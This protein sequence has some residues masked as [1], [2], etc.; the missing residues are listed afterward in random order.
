MKKNQPDLQLNAHQRHASSF[1]LTALQHAYW[2][3]EQNAYRLHTPAYLHGC[4]FS[5][6]IDIP[7]LEAAILAVVQSQPSLT[8][9]ILDDGTQRPLPPPNRIAVSVNDYSRVTQETAKQYLAERKAT[10]ESELPP[11]DRGLRFA[12]FIDRVANGYYV[13]F[14]FRLIA[15][16]AMSIWLFLNDMCAA[17]MG[18]GMPKQQEARFA[19]FVRQRLDLMKSADYERSLKYWQE[20]A[21]ELPNAPELP[22]VDHD[23]I[24]EKSEFRRIQLNLNAQQVEALH[25]QARKHGVGV[26]NLLCTMYADVLRLWSKNSSFIINMLVTH[27]PDDGRFS[28]V[29]GNFGSTVPVEAEDVPGGLRERARALQR[30][31]LPNLKHMRVPGVEVIRAMGRSGSILPAMPVVFASSLGLPMRDLLSP[32]DIGWEVCAGGLQTPQVLLD[33]QVYMD[34]DLLRLNWDYVV[35][36]FLPGV[37]EDMFRAFSEQ[38]LDVIGEA[39]A[40]GL[41]LPQV[42]ESGL[43]ARKAANASGKRLQTGLLHDFFAQACR[44]YPDRPA[45][46]SD[47]RTLA[48]GELWRMTTRLAAE[49]RERQVGRN[50]LVAIVARRGWRQVSAAVAVVQA[51]GAYLPVC[52]ELPAE[53]KSWLVAQQGVKA[54]LVER[55]LAASFELPAGVQLLILED[56]LPDGQSGPAVELPSVQGEQDLAYVIFTSGSTGQ[57]KGV[58]IDHRGAVNTIQDVIDRFGLTAEDRVIGISAFNFDLS[59]Y[60]IFGSLGTGAALVL[61]P[62]SATPSPEDWARLVREHK[63]SVWNTVPALLEMQIEYLGARAAGDLASLRLVMLSGDWIPIGLPGRLAAYLPDATLVSLGGATEASI[64]SNYFV[65]DHVDPAWK[66]IPYGWPLANQYFHVLTKDLR[67]APDW[68]PGDLYIGGIGVAHGYY[69]D[70][71][72]TA[73]S[74]I[75]HPQTGERLYRTGDMGRYN[76]SGYIEFL[77]RN[78]GQVKIRGFRIE[79]G[80]I[81][82]VLGRCPGVRSAAT[83]VRQGGSQDR[84]LVALYVLERDNVS[85]ADL[86][87]HL[88]RTLPDYMVPAQF[89]KLEQ[90]PVTANGKVDRKALADIAA[91][92][93]P[94]ARERCAPRNADERRLAGIWQALLHVDAPGIDDNF[95]E[96]GGTSLLAVRLLN[97]IAKEF[98]RSLP[99]ASLLRHGTIAS[100]AKLLAQSNAPSSPAR[101]PVVVLREGEQSMLIAVH[102]AGG[103]VLCYQEL[104]SLVPDG[105]AVVALQSPGDGS[106]REV[107]ELASRY[108]DALAGQ[109]TSNRPVYLFGWSMGGIIAQE[110]TRQLEA[111]GIAPLGLTMIDS[112]QS[113]D[114]RSGSRLHGYQLLHNFVRDLLGST[115]VPKEFAAIESLDPDRQPEAALA[116]LRDTGVRGGQLSIQEFIALLEEY[117]ANYDALV[118]HAP[119][120]IGTPVRLFRATRR[121]HF[122]LLVNFSMPHG[123]HLES[124]DMDEDHFSITQGAALRTIV[125]LSLLPAGDAGDLPAGTMQ[126]EVPVR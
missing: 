47:A 82:A 54:V 33:C 10:L 59:V 123:G 37:V 53:R 31:M 116:A 75:T 81:D 16:D 40:T 2:L 78:D 115:P 74:F 36:A 120:S 73:A 11:L 62:Y 57:P 8:A 34:G 19:D 122:P 114:C 104:A 76:G 61:P 124:M 26:N 35:D 14:L 29:F 90:I 86:R 108:I 72:R 23:A 45:I 4:F 21:K 99:L 25:A 95:F 105:M 44:T 67:H 113:A 91:A 109:L 101:S 84:Q 41:Y 107:N 64:W 106:P 22:L 112:Y 49:L 69:Q 87:A 30:K 100:Q 5:K 89:I 7:K 39:D 94:A 83:I 50:D 9:E 42:P 60:D 102:P 51:G 96:L 58:M 70:A 68:V 55:E 126:A 32:A 93:P 1:P 17:Y 56:V 103:N 117:R 77:G 48:Y 15:F 13:H 28:H 24:P 12:C 38:I 125:A 111:N 18:R 88:A 6:A 80:E 92:Q 43:A 52:S 46:I 98:G 119:L 97:A 66:S 63:V 121:Q 27:R 71:E 110:M 79:L 20:R 3:G 118:R 85:E 65:V